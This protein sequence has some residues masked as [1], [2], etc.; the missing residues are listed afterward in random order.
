[1]SEE[2]SLRFDFLD[3]Q[4]VDADGL[5]LGRV[6]DVELERAGRA[7]PR[8]TALLTGIEA[9]GGRMD[10]HLGASLARVAERLRPPTSGEGPTRI[11]ADAV[12]SAGAKV[13]LK[14]RHDEVSHVAA[15][16]RWLSE[17]VVSRIPGAE[18]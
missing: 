2:L 15:L 9:L 8:I 1:M 13:E 5:P 14:V 7:A 11:D 18:R 17:R 6:E 4:I 16:E 3:Q 10:G 12:E